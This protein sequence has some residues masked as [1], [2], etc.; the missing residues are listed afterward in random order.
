MKPSVR[1]LGIIVISLFGFLLITTF[2][3]DRS[4]FIYSGKE[5]HKFLQQANYEIDTSQLRTFNE[6]ILIDIRNSDT[7]TMNPL[8]SSVNMPLSNIL[9][10]EY[11][12][13][14][15]SGSPKVLLAYEPIEAHETWMLLTQLGYTD[16]YIIEPKLLIGNEKSDH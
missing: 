7:Y 8:D 3:A 11:K 2:Y 14:L 5:M 10:E 6:P 16:L 1:P 12:S 15:G 9:S 4:Q 13:I